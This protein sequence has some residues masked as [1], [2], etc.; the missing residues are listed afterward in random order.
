MYKYLSRHL[1]L[2]LVAVVML[3]IV[4]AFSVIGWLRIV[5]ENSNQLH[6][7]SRS[8]QERVT[9]VAA[10]SANLLIGYDYSNMEALAD[11]VLSQRD[12]LLVLIKNASGKVMVRRDKAESPNQAGLLFEAPVVFSSETVVRR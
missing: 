8:G 10:A 2:K 6:D 11:R 9:L 3:G 5:E 7:L 1:Q 4:V 12:V